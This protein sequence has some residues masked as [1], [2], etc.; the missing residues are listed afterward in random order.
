MQ[1]SP[2]YN[3]WVMLPEKSYSSLLSSRDGDDD[4]DGT[5]AVAPTARLDLSLPPVDDDG[6]DDVLLADD[7]DGTWTTLPVLRAD[8]TCGGDCQCA[9]CCTGVSEEEDSDSDDDA[10]DDDDDASDSDYEWASESSD[11]IR[12]SDAPLAPARPARR[13]HSMP[14]H[15]ATFTSCRRVLVFV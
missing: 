10:S 8:G 4:G 1:T 6:G 3:G 15:D 2:P 12:D 11:G 14:P 5:Y 9:P 13:S 7:N